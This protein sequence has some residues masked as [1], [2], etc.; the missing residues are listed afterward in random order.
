MELNVLHIN[1]HTA[2]RGGE[3]QVHYIFNGVYNTVHTFLFC[4]EGAVLAQKNEVYKDR[5]FT[6][7]KRFG[8]D[9]AA[10]FRLKKICTEKSINLIHLHDSHSINTYRAA[11]FFGLEVPCIIHRRVNFPVTSRWKYNHKNVQKI[12]CISRA[13]KTTMM[14]V[15][16]EHQ[17]AVIYS[18]IH[19][20]DYSA[21]PAS[22]KL[23]QELN[24]SRD[25]KI[26]GMVTSMEKEKNV[27]EFA[28]IAAQLKTQ[29]NDTEFVVTGG[30]SLLTGFKKQYP[31]IHFLGFRNDV[32]ELLPDIDVFLFTSHSEGLGTAV[33]EAM[34]AEVPVVCR[35]FPT[36]REI[37]EDNK[38]GFIYTSVEDAVQKV[39]TLLD[40]P[41]KRNEFS[42]AARQR[43]QQFD[44]TLMNQEIE[45]LYLSLHLNQ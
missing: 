37:I 23:K 25:K 1:S 19:L 9:L 30:G 42:A 33:L 27:D 38:S 4:P 24:I 32:P 41:E 43:V 35:N 28:A 17:L 45:S 12:I 2:W 13:V 18:G 11:V 3:Q 34:A 31:F 15:V 29:R 39:N 5:V 22:A 14:P 6:Y 16:P 21:K 8:L 40:N 44:V 20:P 10:A 36:A 7:K 26:V